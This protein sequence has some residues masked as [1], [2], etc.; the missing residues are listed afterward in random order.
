VPAQAI[1]PAERDL[2]EQRRWW[3]VEP[4]AILCDMTVGKHP[5]AACIEI[6]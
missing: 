4:I 2:E 5:T 6:S 3:R 1:S